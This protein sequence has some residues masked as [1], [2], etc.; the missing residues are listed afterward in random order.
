M[1]LDALALETRRRIYEYVLGHPGAYVREVMRALGMPQGQVTY[2]LDYLEGRGLLASSK[3]EYH[4]RYFVAGS[5]PREQRRLVRFLRARVPRAVLVALLEEPGLGHGSLA[6]RVGV[7]PPTLSYH[8][9]R[10]G[11]E[12]VVARERAGAEVRYRVAEPERVV[13]AMVLFQRTLMDAA[14]DRFLASWLAVHPGHARARAL[15]AAEPGPA[16]GKGPEEAPG[17]ELR[18]EG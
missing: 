2:H 11:R 7:S 12:G 16:G 14:V 10:L 9:A 17:A 1:P 5:V 13:D 3:E 18:E 4:K 15:R 8:M 6:A